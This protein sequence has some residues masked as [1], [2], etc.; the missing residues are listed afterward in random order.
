MVSELHIHLS[1]GLP[2]ALIADW[3]SL[4]WHRLIMKLPWSMSGDNVVRVNLEPFAGEPEEIVSA[5]CRVQRHF[6]G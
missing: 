5:L 3:R 1:R 4:P 6:G 2:N